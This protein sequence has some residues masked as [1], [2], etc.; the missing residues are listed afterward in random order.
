MILALGTTA[1]LASVTVPEIL[2]VE[3]VVC[4]E[5]AEHKTRNTANTAIKGNKLE[6]ALR[7]GEL[8]FGMLDLPLEEFTVI[9]S[10]RRDFRFLLSLCREKATRHSTAIAHPNRTAQHPR[11]D[12]MKTLKHRTRIEVFAYVQ[13]FPSQLDEKEMDVQ[14][15]FVVNSMES[16]HAAW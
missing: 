7:L 5:A 10:F 14:F 13:Q 15:S 9:F 6:T 1:P 12:R 11:S 4:A 3:I 2:P 8:R 16:S